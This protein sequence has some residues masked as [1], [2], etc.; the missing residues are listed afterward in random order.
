VH[1]GG[2]PELAHEQDGSRCAE[3]VALCEVL[4]ELST[5]PE[6]RGHLGG[7]AGLTSPQ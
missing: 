3:V 1:V 2:S 6:E 5:D 7:A 4:D